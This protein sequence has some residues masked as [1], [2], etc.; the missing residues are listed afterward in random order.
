MDTKMQNA[1]EWIL[2]VLDD[3]KKF[4]ELN[5]LSELKLALEACETAYQNDLRSREIGHQSFYGQQN[6]H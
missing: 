1:D 5:F 3:L 6:F 4:S 2:Q